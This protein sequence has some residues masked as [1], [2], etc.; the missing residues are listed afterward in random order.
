MR[1]SCFAATV[2][3]IVPAFAAFT[4]EYTAK[5]LFELFVSKLESL[6]TI[7]CLT[8]F[9][10][11]CLHKAVLQVGFVEFGGQRSELGQNLVY[12][13]YFR[14]EVVLVYMEGKKS[15]DIAHSSNNEDRGFAGDHFRQLLSVNR[16]WFVV[17]SVVFFEVP[18]AAAVGGW[19]RNLEG[20]VGG[21]YNPSD[22][23]SRRSQTGGELDGSLFFLIGLKR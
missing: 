17:I 19:S 21:S 7:V 4:I 6:V 23:R 9:A 14:C 13:S 22:N 3:D 18:G 15:A 11:I 12:Q 10:S 16:E 1:V 2:K 5:T 20:G 8:W